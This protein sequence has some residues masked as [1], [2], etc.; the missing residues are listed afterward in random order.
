MLR[1]PAFNLFFIAWAEAFLF[2]WGAASDSSIRY[3]L[4]LISSSLS[5]VLFSKTLTSYEVY[6][7]SELVED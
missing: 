1:I 3:G 5:Y 6:F 7:Y 4:K 2:V